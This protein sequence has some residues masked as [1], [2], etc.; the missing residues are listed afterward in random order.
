MATHNIEKYRKI[1]I[2]SH[3]PN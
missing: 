1:P 3:H 2:K